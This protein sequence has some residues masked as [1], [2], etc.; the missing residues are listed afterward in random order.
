SGS[1]ARFASNEFAVLLDNTDLS[2]GQQVA[3]QLL[4]T[5]DKPMF[6]DNQLISVT[7]SGGLA[8]SPLHGRNPQTLMRKAG[9][10]LH[11]ANANGK[12]QVQVFTEAL[13][14]EAS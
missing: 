9:L 10:A 7:G 3:N 13:N 14:A 11:K 5:L 6:V 1:L 12:H 8:C 2:A 4:A